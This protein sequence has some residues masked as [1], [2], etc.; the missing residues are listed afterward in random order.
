MARLNRQPVRVFHL[1]KGL[2]RGGAEMLLTDGPRCSDPEKF[3][4][5]F[6]Y[7]LPN[8]DA[9]VAELRNEL[10]EVTCFNA[11][12]GPAIL[13][14]TLQVAQ[15]L[16]RW[17]ADLLHCHLPLAG[18]AGRLAAFAAQVPVV[19]TEHNA[20][21]RYHPATQLAARL[22]WRLQRKVI[23]VSG[24]VKASVE[25]NLGHRVP[26]EVVRNGVSLER[27]TP[28][29]LGDNRARVRVGLAGDGPVVGAVAVF[30]TQKRLD[31]WLEV[32]SELRHTIPNIRFLLVGDG[33]LR[34]EVE[35]RIR[36]LNLS[37][38]VILPGLQADVRP[39]LAA[40]DVYL[41]TSDF[42][43]IPIA[44]L[45]AMAMQVTP[46]V[47]DAGGMPEVVEDGTSGF[48]LP[49]NDKPGLIAA[50]TRLL[51]L[52]PA[53]RYSYACAARVRVGGAF[54]TERMMRQI[55]QVYID[56]LAC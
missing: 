11:V 41:M 28:P 20:I 43:G 56:A 42:E 33:P 50:V 7:F 3:Q 55:E 22:T 25:R 23:A 16:R 54:S 45:E 18:V 24:D 9:L 1:I 19:Y 52:T 51:Q 36:E 34:G 2:G 39:F 53:Q 15:Q 47:T 21:E 13:A 31:L 12:G 6:G 48:V 49:R 40:M 44:L 32:A 17:K 26:V 35:A 30:R 38:H 37:A 8:K 46:V 14:R 5:A 10:G 27:F 29:A 4:Y